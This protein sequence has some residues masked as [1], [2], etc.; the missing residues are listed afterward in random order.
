MF[1]R[2][3]STKGACGTD[4][5]PPSI[6]GQLLFLPGCVEGAFGRECDLTG[7]VAAICR[8]ARKAD[9][10]QIRHD[11]LHRHDTSQRTPR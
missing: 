4:A 3:V 8:P 9:L 1:D 5:D 2:D 7:A 11:A 10:T 6:I